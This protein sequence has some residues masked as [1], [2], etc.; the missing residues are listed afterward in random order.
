MSKVIFEEKELLAAKEV[1]G[2]RATW[3]SPVL[4]VDNIRLASLK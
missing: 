3:T 4:Q 1:V 2:L